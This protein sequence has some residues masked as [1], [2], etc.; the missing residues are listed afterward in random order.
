MVFL[1]VAGHDRVAAGGITVHLVLAYHA[2]CR[3]L[4]DHKTGIQSGIGNQK[5]RQSPKAHDQLRDTAFGN[6]TQLS[7]SIARKSYEIANGWPWKLPPEMILSSSGKI[8][9]LSVTELISVSNT[10]ET[11]RIASFVAPCTCGMQRNEYGSCTCSFFR[12]ISSLP[13]RMRRKASPVSICPGCGRICW[14]QSI[15]GSIR[16]SKASS[17]KAA[18]RSARFDTAKHASGQTRRWHS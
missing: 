9:G 18:I 13:S 14:M 4:R 11:Y 7:Q 17:D 15:K 6:I 8:V 2:G 1:P 16:P 10:P 5:F 3:I 12:L